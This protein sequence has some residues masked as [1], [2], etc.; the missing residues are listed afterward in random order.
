MSSTVGCGRVTFHLHKFWPIARTWRWDLTKMTCGDGPKPPICGGDQQAQGLKSHLGHVFDLSGCSQRKRWWSRAR[1]PLPPLCLLWLSSCWDLRL[2]CPLGR[3]TIQVRSPHSVSS[4]LG[5]AWLRYRLSPS[6]SGP[7]A[8][9]SPGGRTA[10][11][12]GGPVHRQMAQKLPSVPSHFAICGV[13]G[14]AVNHSMWTA[15]CKSSFR[16]CQQCH[17]DKSTG[18]CIDSKHFETSACNNF[19]HLCHSKNMV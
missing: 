6:L 16:M 19:N 7:P 12:W 2:G 10:D 1:L 4:C 3:K 11:L 9:A 17:P 15:T 5:P 14:R 8:F 13:A 18:F